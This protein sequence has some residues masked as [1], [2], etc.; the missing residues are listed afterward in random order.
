MS[1]LTLSRIDFRGPSRKIR[2]LHAGSHASASMDWD[3][4][5]ARPVAYSRDACVGADHLLVQFGGA[6][7]TSH[8]VRAAAGEDNPLGEVR[9]FDVSL[10]RMGRSGDRAFIDLSRLRH[11]PVSDLRVRWNWQQCVGE[12]W[13]DLCQTEHRIFLTLGEPS[14]PWGTR[15]GGQDAWVQ[16]LALATD[17]AA[18]A[19]SQLDAAARI[20]RA[21]NRRAGYQ[22]AQQYL[23]NYGPQC[24]PTFNLTRFLHDVR[25][26][27]DLRMNCQDFA[28]A[29]VTLAN[30]LG[31]TLRSAILDHL[32]ETGRVATA[33]SD[34]CAPESW[35]TQPFGHHEVCWGA[36]EGGVARVFDASLHV[37]LDPRVPESRP[38]L[39]ADLAFGRV[40][41]R[42]SYCDLLLPG[43]R[44]GFAAYP[45]PYVRRVI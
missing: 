24:T 9:A 18:G 21:L 13:R 2:L 11:Q 35:E 10:N 16:V 22:D 4:G 44:H 37:T 29:V 23:L 6:A 42:G 12:E 20:T 14:A 5:R 26:P 45:L 39:P 3:N 38:L 17:W 33:G 31:C 19:R 8:R 43:E 34:V 36:G 27:A 28:A 1:G 41:A 30:V 7:G 15:E 25:A 40:G 32:P